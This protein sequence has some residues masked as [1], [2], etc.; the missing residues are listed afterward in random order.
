MD[1][2]FTLDKN[3]PHVKV[4]VDKPKESYIF[5][6]NSCC[7]TEQFHFDYFKYTGNLKDTGNKFLFEHSKCKSV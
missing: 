5:K 3:V 6:C 7:K 2:E 1:Q 4:F